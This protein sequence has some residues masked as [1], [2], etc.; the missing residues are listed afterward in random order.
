MSKAGEVIKQLL[1][2][3]PGLDNGEDEVN[4][5]DLVDWFNEKRDELMEA[6]ERE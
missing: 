2:A 3:F 6:I 4:G 5:A 1:M